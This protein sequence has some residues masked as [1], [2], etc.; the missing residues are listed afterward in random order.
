MREEMM[1]DRG[2]VV[3]HS[4]LNRARVEVRPEFVRASLAV[5]FE[6]M[7]REGSRNATYCLFERRG[8][9]EQIA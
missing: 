5:N 2:V 1:Q 6:R 7:R 3:D 4:T 9:V 8:D